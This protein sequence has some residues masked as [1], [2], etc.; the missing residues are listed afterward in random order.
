MKLK[1]LMEKLAQVADDPS[2]TNPTTP[3]ARPVLS[4]EE[5]LARKERMRKLIGALAGVEYGLVAGGSL[6]GE[7]FGKKPGQLDKKMMLRGA[8]VGAPLGA[9][10]GYAGGAM[11]NRIKRYTGEEHPPVPQ[12]HLVTEPS[13]ELVQQVQQA[14]KQGSAVGRTLGF[15][16]GMMKASYGV[17]ES[18]KSPTGGM[19]G[20]PNDPF[21]LS[22]GAA[23]Y[24]GPGLAGQ[25]KTPS[26]N[27]PATAS[28]QGS[29]QNASH[30]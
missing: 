12:I 1:D 16:A 30:G 4:E 6:G 23:L 17:T 10:S 24:K 27:G 26:T 29:N 7:L 14:M 22:P 2:E 19:P 28:T 8:M 21:K 13:P 11:L 3:P 15:Y 9:L 25:G 18:P 5:K 20:Q